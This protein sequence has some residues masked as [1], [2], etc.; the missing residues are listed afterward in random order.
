MA[1]A[2]ARKKK[3]PTKRVRMAEA[4]RQA[5]GPLMRSYGFENPAKGQ[6]HDTTSARRD[7]WFRVRG[8][9]RDEVDVQWWDSRPKFRINFRTTQAERSPWG[10]N[11]WGW[12]HRFSASSWRFRWGG[13]LLRGHFTSRF[14]TV[15]G[16][17]RLALHRL[18]LMNAF[19]LSGERSD[20]LWIGPWPD[21]WRWQRIRFLRWVAARLG[22]RVDDPVEG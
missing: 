13:F 10:L 2:V 20:Y 1:R 3:P 18:P 15:D 8:P 5:I 6:H 14:L 17:V 12:T 7:N 19:L 9:Y 16:A 4:I 22:Y 11:E 21:L